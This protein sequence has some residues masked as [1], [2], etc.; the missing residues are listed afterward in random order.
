MDKIDLKKELKHHYRVSSKSV[1]E[2]VVQ[3]LNYLTIDGQGDPNTSSDYKEAVEALFSVSCTV[4]HAVKKG[5]AAIDYAV[6][7]LEGL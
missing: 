1:T 6:V 2:V 3:P 5:P 7:P 4:K